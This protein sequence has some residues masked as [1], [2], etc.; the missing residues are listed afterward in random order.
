MASTKRDDLAKR[1]AERLDKAPAR[2][3]AMS[4]MGADPPITTDRRIQPDITPSGNVGIRPPAQ[5]RATSKR[6]A[7]K[8]A[9]SKQTGPT[10]RPAGRSDVS[11]RQLDARARRPRRGAT[12][13]VLRG[14]LIPDSLHREA[15]RRK[16]ALRSERGRLVTWDDVMSE[17]LDMLVGQAPRVDVTLDGVRRSDAATVRRR[18]VQATLTADLDQD[19]VDMHLDLSERAESGA[20]YE[21]L[22]TTAI[23]LWLDSTA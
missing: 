17:A 3:R 18:L 4:T 8:R 1:L 23:H 21:Q 22:W 9:A 6:A 2:G 10:P 20:T 19:L 15:R 16:A 7:S 14:H 11:P 5:K 13:T 12:G